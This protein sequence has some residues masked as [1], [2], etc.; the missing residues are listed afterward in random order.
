M[1]D[2]E[3]QLLALLQDNWTLEEP[4]NVDET[5]SQKG[6]LFHRNKRRIEGALAQPH[7]I[8]R[9]VGDTEDW[10][11]EGMADCRAVVAVESRISCEAINNDQVEATK[12]Q[13]VVIREE[14]IRILKAVNDGTITAP[15]GWIW[16]FP[17]RRTNLDTWDSPTPMLGEEVMI[18][19]AYERVE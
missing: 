8:F 1:E 14:I 5:G 10:N 15:T 9:E 19:I 2:L 11:N 17:V 7:L 3:L 13:K 18:T 4:L 6:I 16:A 12:A